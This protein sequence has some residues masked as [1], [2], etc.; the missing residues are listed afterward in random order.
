MNGKLW[1]PGKPSFT[2]V[3]CG[4]MGYDTLDRISPIYFWDSDGIE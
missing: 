3:L 1:V 4:K 2:H